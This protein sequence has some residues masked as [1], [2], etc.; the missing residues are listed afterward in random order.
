MKAGFYTGTSMAIPAAGLTRL[1][2]KKKP[3]VVFSGIAGTTFNLFV[4]NVNE[5]VKGFERVSGASS[6]LIDFAKFASSRFSSAGFDKD[7]DY[8]VGEFLKKGTGC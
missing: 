7:R 3:L 1:K 4:A 8:N 5:L 2:L 6:D